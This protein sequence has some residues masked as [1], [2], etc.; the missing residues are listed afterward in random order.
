MFNFP[1][2]KLPTAWRSCCCTT[3]T[4]IST[5]RGTRRSATRWAAST[6]WR[7]RS[8][9]TATQ[10]ATSPKCPAT[11]KK[12][13]C[14]LALWATKQIGARYASVDSTAGAT[15]DKI[16]TLKSLMGDLDIRD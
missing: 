12:E 16:A 9:I 3:P 13:L 6:T 5:T 7:W 8:N 15:Q 4:I 14:N 11:K 2:A 1:V 10:L